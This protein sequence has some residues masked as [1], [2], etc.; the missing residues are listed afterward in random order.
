VGSL[1]IALLL[2]LEMQRRVDPD[3]IPDATA[4]IGLR[5]VTG[6]RH[7]DPERMPRS[8]TRAPTDVP[9]SPRPKEQ[10]HP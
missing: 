9:A 10:L 4:V 8:P 6:L 2:G 3:A 7:I 5:A 1:L